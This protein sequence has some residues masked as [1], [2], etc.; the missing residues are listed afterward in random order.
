MALEETLMA[1][2]QERRKLIAEFLERG[3]KAGALPGGLR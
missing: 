3:R 1:M 2:E